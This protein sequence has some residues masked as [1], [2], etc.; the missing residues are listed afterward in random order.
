MTPVVDASVAIKWFVNEEGSD[1][2]DRLLQSPQRLCAPRLLLAEFTNALWKNRTRK[3]IGA[4]QARQALASLQRSIDMW[5]PTEPLLDEALR[6]AME[7]GHP[8]YDMVYLALA[9]EI[10]S[11]VVTA[12][13]RLL[14]KIAGTALA[15]LAIYLADW[16][17]G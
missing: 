11:Q 3:T 4:E 6:L 9:R 8:I 15:P 17:P 13:R 7:L 5:R 10:G 16:R 14:N 2:A 1:S 12:D